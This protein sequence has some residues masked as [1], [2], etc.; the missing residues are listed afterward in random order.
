MLGFWRSVL[1]DG[2][3]DREAE[4]LI[5]HQKYRPTIKTLDCMHRILRLRSLLKDG[6][7]VRVSIVRVSIVFRGRE[8]INDIERGENLL[9]LICRSVEDIATIVEGPQWEGRRLTVVLMKRGNKPVKLSPERKKLIEELSTA[10]PIP[11]D[12]NKAI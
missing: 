10:R 3:L 5:A 9:S 7:P 1:R 11:V 6:N 4:D 8:I 12:I 2:L